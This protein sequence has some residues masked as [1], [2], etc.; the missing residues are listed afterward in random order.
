MGVFDF[1]MPVKLISGC[2]CIKN[3]KKE[4]DIGKSCLIVTGKTSAQMS[5]ALGDVTK[6]L[7][8]LKITYTVFDKIRENPLL[9]TVEEGGKLASKVDFV[10][11]IGG[12]SALDASKAVAA[13]AANPDI[14]GEEIFD[15]AV[16]PSLPLIVV[17][18]TSGTGSEANNYSILTL[19]GKNRKKT[20]KNAYSY[21][22]VAFLDP[23][24]TCSLGKKYTIST[25][26]DA[27]AHSIES[28]M[29]PK[30]TDISRMMAL[31]ASRSIWG[32]IKNDHDEFTLEERETLQKASCAAG[33]AINTTGTGFPHP[34]GYNLT[35]Y[36]GIPHGCACA[37][38]E[39]A[40]IK[41][42]SKSPI[43]ETL[44]K[45]F[46]FKCAFD[47]D[48]LA[49]RLS[50]LADVNITLTDEEIELFINQVGGAGNYANNPYVIS[51]DEMREIYKSI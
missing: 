3:S 44:M 23:M 12:G 26:L 25:A 42:T 6:V 15:K 10:I 13:F 14:T 19:D 36:K 8:G 30:T 17:P 21:P 27:F 16:N 1:L 18:T 34:L 49:C 45:S 39:K 47:L 28:Y 38:F 41:Y 9:S 51:R 11:G 37:V 50:K 46:A 33:I 20:F 31:Y 29:S 4:F 24:Y 7:D 35:L 48:E 43:G 2:G 22:D 40:F 5:G 32:I